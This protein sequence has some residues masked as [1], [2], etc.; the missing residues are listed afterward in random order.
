[1]KSDGLIDAWEVQPAEASM[2]TR[3]E[4]LLGR[5]RTALFDDSEILGTTVVIGDE[6]KTATLAILSQAFTVGPI[7]LQLSNLVR[8]KHTSSGFNPYYRV[9][10]PNITNLTVPSLPYS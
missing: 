9:R 3:C 6:R 5:P 2:Q 8:Q 10:P 4:K 1:M 7:N